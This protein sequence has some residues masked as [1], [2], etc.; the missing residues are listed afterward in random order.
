[1]H[2]YATQ[3]PLMKNNWIL[4]LAEPPNFLL[5]LIAYKWDTICMFSLGESVSK[6]SVILTKTST[7]WFCWCMQVSQSG[8]SHIGRSNPNICTKYVLSVSFFYI[9]VISNAANKVCKTPKIEKMKWWLTF[10]PWVWETNNWKW[11]NW[12]SPASESNESLMKK[13]ALYH[14][15]TH[16][17]TQNEGVIILFPQHKPLLLSVWNRALTAF[18]GL[19]G[20]RYMSFFRWR[21]WTFASDFWFMIASWRVFPGCLHWMYC[22]ELRDKPQACFTK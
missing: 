11:S 14:K 10:F 7:C 17:N 12:K 22:I 20:M 5:T 16:W 6:L 21:V 2:R 15:T 1:M 18:F 4:P 13:I 3:R 19:I 8:M 9:S